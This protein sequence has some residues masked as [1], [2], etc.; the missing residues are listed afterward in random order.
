MIASP[1]LDFFF[2]S[3]YNQTFLSKPISCKPAFSADESCPPLEVEKH[4]FSNTLDHPLEVTGGF[5]T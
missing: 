1:D 4:R 3:F 5:A 2:F